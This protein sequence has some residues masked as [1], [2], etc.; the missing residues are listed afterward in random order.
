[1]PGLRPCTDCG[2]PYRTQTER[3]PNP[4]CPRSRRRAN[5][6]QQGRIARSHRERRRRAAAV[7][8]HRARFGEW[9]PGWNVPAHRV[10]PPNRLSADHIVPQSLGGADGP[11]QV[12]CVKCNTARGGANR[13]RRPAS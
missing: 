13:L 7:A 11:L 5:P 10:V 1:M 3:C 12:R 6:G 8:E 9:C 2:T 4:R